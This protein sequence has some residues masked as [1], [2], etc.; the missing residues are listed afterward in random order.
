L[1]GKYFG[2]NYFLIFWWEILFWQEILFGRKYLLGGKYLLLGLLDHFLSLHFF[3]IKTGMFYFQQKSSE[4]LTESLLVVLICGLF[5]KKFGS[6]IYY[7]M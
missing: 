5:D 2:G 1:G 3:I 4:L 6:I 7:W